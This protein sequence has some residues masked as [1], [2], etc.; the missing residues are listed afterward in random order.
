MSK[1]LKIGLVA[2]ILIFLSVF[3]ILKNTQATENI[4]V[5]TKEISAGTIV[6][7]DMVTLKSVP[8]TA[9]VPDSARSVEEVVGKRL[10]VTRLKGDFI[11]RNIILEK[12]LQITAGNVLISAV[13][14][15]EDSTLISAGSKVT[16]VL[17]QNTA[18][19]GPQKATDLKVLFIKQITS[20]INGST[21][22]I[23]FLETTPDQA[24]LI[25]PYVKSGAFKL[26]RQ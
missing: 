24:A 3:L 8:V 22:T 9:I 17:L 25:A 4:V 20:P 1:I 26:I 23:A 15:P 5:A 19:E 7:S 11:P 2:G 16:L 13:I 6:T 18:T 21:E 14:P 12:D 10:D